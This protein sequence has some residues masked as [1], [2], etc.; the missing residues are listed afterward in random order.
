MNQEEE[1]A[2]SIIEK[3]LSAHLQRIKKI[4]QSIPKIP[5]NKNN[6]MLGLAHDV[7]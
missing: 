4:A 2:M 1:N 5:N 7:T 3:N 6:T